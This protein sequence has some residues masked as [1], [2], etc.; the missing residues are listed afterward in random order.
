MMKILFFA[1]FLT[2]S[3]LVAQAQTFTIRGTISDD[4]NT[5]LPGATLLLLHPNDSTMLGF[6][7]TTPTGNFEVQNLQRRNYLMRIT[8]IGF[9]TRY[10]SVAPPEGAALDM[11]VLKLETERT[12]LGE[13]VVAQERVHMRL[14]GD[15]I[16]YDALA[17]NPRPNEV[18]EDVLKRMPGMEVQSDGNVVAQGETVSRVLVN[19]R[20]FF[21]RDPRMATQNL[22]ADAVERVQ[23]FDRRSEQAQ[24]TGID[25]GERE[26]TINLELRENRRIG[27][28]GNSSLAYGTENRFQGRTNINHFDAK[29]Q[30]SILGMGNNVNQTGFSIGEFLNFSGGMQGFGGGGGGGMQMTVTRG[31]GGSD[32]PLSFDGRPS[33]NGLMT[34]WAGGVNFNRRLGAKTELT[35]SYFYNQL[36]HDL[37]Q[38]LER[39][40]FMPAGNFFFD[41]NSNQESRNYN[42]RL[43]LRLLHQF[44]ENSSLLFTSNSTL[45]STE[46]EAQS[47]SENL[48]HQSALQNR[49]F[50]TSIADGNRN[51]VD[52]SLLW[53]QRL[54]KPGRTFTSQINF[55]VNNNNTEGYLEALNEFFLPALVQQQLFQNNFQN[56]ANRNFGGNVTYTEPIAPN[57]FLEANYRISFNHNEV[58]QT[59]Y[60]IIG[61][62]EVLNQQ[63]SNIFDN[64]F[65]FQ[66]GGINYR[67]TGENFNLTLGTNVQ[68]STLTGN[69]LTTNQEIQRQSTH[70][71]PVLRFNYQFT[72]TRRLSLDYTTNVQEPS[73]QQLQP[74]VDNRDPLN[75]FMGNPNLKSSY[76]HRLALRFN[77]FNPLNNFGFFAFLSADYVG[78]AI[79]NA[80]SVDPQLV[81]TIIPVNVDQNLNIRSNANV[82]MS[83]TPIKSRLS[84]G[85]SY[86]F[87]QS[88]NILNNVNQQISNNILGFNTRFSFIPN[89]NFEASL[90]ANINQQLTQYEFRTLEQAFL[91]QTFGTDISWRFLNY[92]RLGANFSYQM[93]EGRTAEFDRNIPMLDFF[94]SRSFLRGNAGE[95]RLSG[96]NL[97][98]QNLGVMQSVDANFIQRQVTNSLGQ[99]FLLTFTYS[100]NQ[101]MNMFDGAQ[102]QGGGRGMR[103]IMH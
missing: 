44:S 56:S 84:G 15:T 59:V 33:T 94:I 18:V 6:G 36:G 42:H 14:R 101:A 74:F 68:F 17:F 43:N 12:L 76:R 91:N 72:S 46:S 25:D 79:T 38:E 80:V 96:F 64:T 30:L 102:R 83:F 60:D 88:V 98:N 85:L 13:V 5:G 97:L 100:L 51:N 81:R 95:L 39:E 86:N 10:L 73:V 35:A 57:M 50:Q 4:Q 27:T 21:G 32:I 8:Y 65:L 52:A 45:N 26:R 71:L 3:A 62:N 93:F 49:S 75:I 70:F 28:F 78:N 89:D 67:L 87:I 31:G 40:N 58:D 48:N 77:S 1:G 99:Y 55:S 61:Q 82:N 2:L 66:R 19:G 23:V 37:T 34:S 20:E 63:L 41:Q 24:F 16:E 53:R 69:I 29:G 92:F 11:G 9:V 90:T 54:G 103:M 22:P 47:R 7:I